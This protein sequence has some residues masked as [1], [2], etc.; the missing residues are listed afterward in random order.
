MNANLRKVYL[1]FMDLNLGI[2]LLAIW[3]VFQTSALAWVIPDKWDVEELS[4]QLHDPS[5]E[6]IDL[7]RCHACKSMVDEIRSLARQNASEDEIASLATKLCIKL[8][9]EDKSVCTQ[10]V[11]EFKVSYSKHDIVKCIWVYCRVK[12][13]MCLLRL[14][15]G[16]RRFVAFSLVRVVDTPMIPGIKSGLSHFLMFQSL[17]LLTH[18]MYQRLVSLWSS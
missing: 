16:R 3:L 13:F 11:Q 18:Q 15:S 2:K 7:N 1:E 12:Y 6:L 4:K 9:I 5:K 8:K 14:H 17:H 10:I